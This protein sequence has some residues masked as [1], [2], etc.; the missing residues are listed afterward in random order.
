LS[1]ARPGPGRSTVTAQGSTRTVL[2][3]A[4]ERGNIVAA[5]IAARELGTITLTEALELTSL[6]A[7]RDPR[8]RGRRAGARWLQRWLAE[9]RHPT[10]DGAVMV[11]GLLAAL[12][13]GAHDPALLALRD[14]A[15]RA[16]SASGQRQT[17]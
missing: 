12:G 7:K 8:I 2:H 14:V 9:A 6:I 16:T 10:I 13:G 3:R 11:S 17:G 1:V 4:L 15:R 5:E